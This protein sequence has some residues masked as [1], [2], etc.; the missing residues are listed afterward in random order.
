MFENVSEYTSTY[1]F[2]SIFIIKQILYCTEYIPSTIKIL[3]T[4]IDNSTFDLNLN[5]PIIYQFCTIDNRERI[6]CLVTF[7]YR[8]IIRKFQKLKKS[9][10]NSKD[11]ETH[12]ETLEYLKYLLI[13]PVRI[14]P[15]A[16][17]YDPTLPSQTPL[18]TTANFETILEL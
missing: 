17:Q 11:K 4:I 12:I 18:T 16:H 10:N 6:G 1:Q 5:I 2:Q 15:K 9:N 3:K 7:I 14:T 13:I 8:I